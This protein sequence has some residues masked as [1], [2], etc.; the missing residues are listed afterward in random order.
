M[1]LAEYFCRSL[2]VWIF[3]IWPYP[4]HSPMLR[5]QAPAWQASP[6]EHRPSSSVPC[7]V[8]MRLSRI[9]PHIKDEPCARQRALLGVFSSR[10]SSVSRGHQNRCSIYFSLPLVIFICKRKFSDLLV[11]AHKYPYSLKVYTIRQMIAK[12]L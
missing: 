10:S 4:R 3:Q 1:G 6:W 7:A 8:P 12:S 2:F 11:P 9:G 5:P